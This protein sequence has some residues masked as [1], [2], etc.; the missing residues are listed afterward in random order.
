MATLRMQSLLSSQNSLVFKP[1]N[2]SLAL[3]SS[4]T[5]VLKYFLLNPLD[6]FLEL[7]ISP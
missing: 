4:N 6:I 1:S 3:V 2:F 5:L 7:L